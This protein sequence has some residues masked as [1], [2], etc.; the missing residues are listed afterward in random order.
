M[1]N[2]IVP[3]LVGE[4]AFTMK[5]FGPDQGAWPAAA[6]GGSLPLTVAADDVGIDPGDRFADF[7]S[8]QQ[9][10]EMNRVIKS[11]WEVTISAKLEVQ[12]RI[13][14]MFVTNGPLVQFVGTAQN[15]ID[16]PTNDLVI[17]GSG[18]M[19]SPRLK[20][21]DPS[22]IEISIKSYG[23]ALVITPSQPLPA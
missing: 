3:K 9:G 4:W 13:L 10:V 21:G 23:T 19:A 22:M 6:P 20:P 5:G 14:G 17:T 15:L 1:P 12:N 18:I 2:Y 16:S 11:G 7:A 8:S